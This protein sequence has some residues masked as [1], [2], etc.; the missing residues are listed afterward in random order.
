MSL[1]RGFPF[2]HVKS[3]KANGWAFWGLAACVGLFSGDTLPVMAV[4]VMPS[5]SGCAVVTL[6]LEVERLPADAAD[7][8]ELAGAEAETPAAGCA[9][10]SRSA[11]RFSS[12]STRSNRRRSRSVNGAGA[13]MFV[14]GLAD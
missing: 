1:V 10:P 2:S 3:A 12:C 13:S 11:T 14:T 8:S 5:D 7:G 6:A 4:L 9:L